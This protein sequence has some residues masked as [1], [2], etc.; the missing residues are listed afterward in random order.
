MNAHDYIKQLPHARVS[1]PRYRHDAEMARVIALL[2]QTRDSV[3]RRDVL[4][5]SQLGPAAQVEACRRAQS[6]AGLSILT[7]PVLTQPRP[8]KQPWQGNERRSRPR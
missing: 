1:K 5:S 6:L 3:E 7:G 4:V 8:G 2:A